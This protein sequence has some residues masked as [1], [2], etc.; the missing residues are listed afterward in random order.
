MPQNVNNKED[1]FDFSG[2]SYGEI[3]NIYQG[4]KI[5]NAPVLV[6]AVLIGLVIA[7]LNLIKVLSQQNIDKD[8]SMSIVAFIALF[9]E[10]WK[11]FMFIALLPIMWS[12]L[13]ALFG[14]ISDFYLASFGEPEGNFYDKIADQIATLQQKEKRDKNF[15]SYSIFDIID[16][17]LVIGIQP[18][19]VLIDQWTYSIAIM[20]QFFFKSI[21]EM[22]GGVAIAMMLNDRTQQYFF[23][24]IKAVFICY[25]LIPTFLLADILVDAVRDQV[26]IN[27]VKGEWV[28]QIVALFTAVKILLFASGKV[29]LWRSI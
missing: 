16:Y 1:F 12:I 17:I 24:W 26:V 18:F 19:I 8:G 15:F 11:F 20:Y 6:V 9:K 27:A 23:T 7:V 28:V 22:M 3:E 29:L 13:E 14:S 5:S 2:L 21:L 4:I 25:M 10:K